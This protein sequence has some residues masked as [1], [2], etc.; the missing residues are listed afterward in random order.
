MKRTSAFPQ[1]FSFR[2]SVMN[3][4]LAVSKRPHFPFPGPDSQAILRA[5]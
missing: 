4:N 5:G 2:T 3:Q 1:S